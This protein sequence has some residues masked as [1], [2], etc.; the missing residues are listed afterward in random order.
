MI[1]EYIGKVVAGNN[2]SLIEVPSKDL[3]GRD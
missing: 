1:D 2:H 3:P